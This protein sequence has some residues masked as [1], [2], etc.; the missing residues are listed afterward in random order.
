[1]VQVEFPVLVTQYVVFELGVTEIDELFSP[2]MMV[3]ASPTVLPVPHVYVEPLPSVPPLAV[4]VVGL[5]LQMVVVPE[6]EV[7]SVGGS[8]II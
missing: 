4:N 6:I 1:M 3:G 7:G 2:L 5:P 8:S